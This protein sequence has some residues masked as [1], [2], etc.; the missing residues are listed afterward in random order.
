MKTNNNNH[1]FG[2]RKLKHTGEIK[3]KNLGFKRISKTIFLK[4]KL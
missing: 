2:F 1:N 4:L 3:Q